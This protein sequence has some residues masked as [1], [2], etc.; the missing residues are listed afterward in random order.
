MSR[1]PTEIT[2]RLQLQQG[3]GGKLW[4]AIPLH[5][6]HYAVL[7]LPNSAAARSVI[8]P[9]T[10]EK[11]KSTNLAGLTT[12]QIRSRRQGVVLNALRLMGHQL[13]DLEFQVRHVAELRLPD[14]RYVV[15]GY[16]G[17]DFFMANF[18]AMRY[19][20]RTFRLTLEL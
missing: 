2:F 10:F 1:Q 4:F 20:F 17:L 6:E 9:T 7:M 11:L 12:T 15:D 3:H 8:T 13:L 18:T 5:V 16:L 14:G 19:E